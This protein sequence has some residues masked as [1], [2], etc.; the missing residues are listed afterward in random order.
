MSPEVS[1]PLPE[2]VKGDDREKTYAL[3]ALLFPLAVAQLAPITT[4]FSEIVTDW[5]KWS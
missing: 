3:P 5:P 2:E 1:A 4:V